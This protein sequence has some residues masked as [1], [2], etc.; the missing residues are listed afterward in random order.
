MP[1]TQSGEYT[2]R[3]SGFN[4]KDMVTGLKPNPLEKC[5]VTISPIQPVEGD[6][7][8]DLDIVSP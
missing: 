2:L 1:L 4:T 3:L 7:S 8:V 6:G 5:T